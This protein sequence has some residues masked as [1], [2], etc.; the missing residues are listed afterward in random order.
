MQ[1]TRWGGIYPSADI[2]SVYSTAQARRAS[3][4]K[5]SLFEYQLSTSNL[6]LKFDLF[7]N[8]WL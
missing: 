7:I 6:M 5:V 4:F 3:H 1:D 8:D 2:Q